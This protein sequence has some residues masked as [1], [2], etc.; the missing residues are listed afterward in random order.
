MY[1]IMQQCT[2]LFTLVLPTADENEA[3]LFFYIIAISQPTNILPVVQFLHPRPLSSAHQ[4]MSVQR[5]HSKNQMN[6]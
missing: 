6:I 3:I 4:T 5:P 2:Q 1:S